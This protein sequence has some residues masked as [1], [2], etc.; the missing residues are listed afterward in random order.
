MRC[1]H[2]HRSGIP[3]SQEVCP[4][5]G[6]HLPSRLRD[7]L[8]SGTRLRG[9]T[10][11]VDYAL[12]RGGFGI[13]YRAMHVALEQQV[14]IKEFYPREQALRDGTTGQLSVPTMHQSSYERALKR[15][16]REGQ[17]LA[18]MNHPGV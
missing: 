14:A 10:Y 16:M 5:C 4:Q 13:T 15:F 6:V 18:L 8:P 17:I 12:G 11:H 7:V 3:V 1:L 9:G 2:C